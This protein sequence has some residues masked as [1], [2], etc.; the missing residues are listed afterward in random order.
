MSE[1][2]GSPSKPSPAQH[3]RGGGWKRKE[4]GRK[5]QTQKADRRTTAV[6][7][8]WGEFLLLPVNNTTLLILNLLKVTSPKNTEGVSSACCLCSS[9][10]TIHTLSHHTSAFHAYNIYQLYIIVSHNQCHSYNLFS[11]LF[12]I[13]FLSMASYLHKR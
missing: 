9:L 4:E 13:P 2:E 8:A 6:R 5:T 7:A 11:C 10:H 12:M 3:C 1:K